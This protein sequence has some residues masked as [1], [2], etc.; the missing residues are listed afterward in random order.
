MGVGF[1]VEY[2]NARRV[3]V[4]HA[5]VKKTQQTPESALKIARRRLKEVRNG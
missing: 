2:F 5:F 3:V 4:L 1:S